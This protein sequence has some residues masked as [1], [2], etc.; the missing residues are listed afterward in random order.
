[1]GRASYLRDLNLRRHCTKELVPQANIIKEDLNVGVI[2]METVPV[3]FDTMRNY[4][5]IVDGEDKQQPFA[6]SFL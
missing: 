1:M 2:M 3:I 6:S 4:S 5:K